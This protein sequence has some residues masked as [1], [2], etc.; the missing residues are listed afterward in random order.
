MRYEEPFK[1]KIER[2][3]PEEEE[4]EE[5]K[6]EEKARKKIQ[7]QEQTAQEIKI[8][9]ARSRP[10]RKIRS[11]EREFNFGVDR[12]RQAQGIRYPVRS[13]KFFP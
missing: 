10:G 7:T 13:F 2:G 6:E 1:V 12:K 5:N 8:K 9:K 11:T 4:E 3:E